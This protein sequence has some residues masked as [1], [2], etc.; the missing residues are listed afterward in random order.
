MNRCNNDWEEHETVHFINNDNMSKVKGINVNLFYCSYSYGAASASIFTGSFSWNKQWLCH[1][2]QGFLGG[3]QREIK[4]L[5]SEKARGQKKEGIVK[6]HAQ[7]RSTEICKML[8]ERDNKK[9]K[10]QRYWRGS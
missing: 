1:T 3:G 5:Q 6:S 4:S 8:N 9:D 7:D 2:R 10:K